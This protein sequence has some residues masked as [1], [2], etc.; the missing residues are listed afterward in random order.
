[1]KKLIRATSNTWI[2]W[3]KIIREYEDFDITGEEFEDLWQEYL[4]DPEM[5]VNTELHINPE[6]SVRGGYGSVYIFDESGENRWDP[7]EDSKYVVDFY[8]W[9]EREF[10]MAR[11]ANNAQE[12]KNLYRKWIKNLIM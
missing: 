5:A 8:D 10:N 3:D 7:F 6:P 2:D 11:K 9:C 4:S 1:M 12:Y